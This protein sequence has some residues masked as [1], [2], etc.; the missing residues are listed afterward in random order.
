MVSAR[1]AYKFPSCGTW[2]AVRRENRARSRIRHPPP[3]P[4]PGP[5][6]ARHNGVLR[7]T[8][9]RAKCRSVA[10][11]GACTPRVAQTAGFARH[12]VSRKTALCRAKLSCATQAGRAQR[13]CEMYRFD[14]SGGPRT[15]DSRESPPKPKRFESQVFSVRFSRAMLPT[16]GQRSTET[17]RAAPSLAHMASGLRLAIRDLAAPTLEQRGSAI[18]LKLEAPQRIRQR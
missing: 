6:F 10:Q 13:F 15:L 1:S 18:G 12:F 7:D 16:A 9:C 8:L 3:V 5:N 2:Q 17:A 11:R 4:D 14:V